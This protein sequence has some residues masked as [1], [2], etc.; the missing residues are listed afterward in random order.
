LGV[1]DRVEYAEEELLVPRGT[2][3]AMVTDG[4]LERRD[5]HRMLGD[6]GVEVALMGAVDLT[7]QGVAD[8]IRQ[9]AADF[10]GTPSDDD[11]AVL[12]LDLGRATD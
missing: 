2:R 11:I 10:A 4:V 1:I 5:G 8:R 12:V 3:L 9:S 7:A 6:E